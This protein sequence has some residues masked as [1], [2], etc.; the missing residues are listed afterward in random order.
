LQGGQS[1]VISVDQNELW[2]ESVMY[3]IDDRC[4]TDHRNLSRGAARR[5]RELFGIASHSA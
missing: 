5:F 3:P 2:W 4:G 1:L